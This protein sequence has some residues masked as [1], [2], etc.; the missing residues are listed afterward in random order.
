MTQTPGSRFCLILVG[1]CPSL[2]LA[3]G[4]QISFLGLSLLEPSLDSS[5]FTQVSHHP[6]VSAFYV[7]NRKDGFCMSGS[8]T[9]KSKFYGEEAPGD[10][11]RMAGP[12]PCGSGG[13]LHSKAVNPRAPVV[14]P[15]MWVALTQL[16]ADTCREPRNK[17][18]AC[19]EELAPT[20]LPNS[21]DISHVWLFV[22]IKG[23][24]DY[25][26]VGSAYPA[27][28]GCVLHP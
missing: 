12:G 15:C 20:E 8:I 28:R 18:E 11:G 26:P 24:L 17:G 4:T 14:G 10:V 13:G 7:S 21:I 19:R 5:L 9:A 2:L 16:K 6:P 1:M 3:H 27:C 22:L 23:G 25:R